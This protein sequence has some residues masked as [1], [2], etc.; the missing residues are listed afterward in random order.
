MLLSHLRRAVEHGVR[1]DILELLS[2]SNLARTNTL[3]LP[4]E[5]Y[6]RISPSPHLPYAVEMSSMHTT[7]DPSTSLGYYIH[8]MDHNRSL[9][10]PRY[11]SGVTTPPKL[12]TILSG[13]L[14]VS[15]TEIQGL[16]RH[17]ETI[18]PPQRE[19]KSSG[20]GLTFSSLW[21]HR[22]KRG[23]GGRSSN[24][25]M[26]TLTEDTEENPRT[27]KPSTNSEG[28]AGMVFS[29]DPEPVSDTE[30]KVD[31][32]PKR[33]HRRRSSTKDDPSHTERE[34][35]GREMKR[36]L[37][38]NPW[39]E[40]SEYGSDSESDGS[41]SP[42]TAQP[43]KPKQTEPSFT[44][45]TP[46]RRS[47]HPNPPPS[48]SSL[49]NHSTHSS[50]LTVV[51]PTMPLVPGH[52]WPPCKANN[53]SGFCKGA[54]KLSSGLGGFKTYTEPIGYYLLISKWRCYRC[55]F[56]MPLAPGS[57]RHDI[58]FDQKIYRHPGTGI[59]YRWSFLAKSHLAYTKPGV[60]AP[61]HVSGS[62]GC[63]FCCAEMNAPAPR[64]ESLEVFMGHLGAQHRA[65]DVALLE[66]TR[67]VVGRVAG[68]EEGFDINIPP[69]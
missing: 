6:Q 27:R 2:T 37:T 52:F 33:K 40:R 28:Y 69:V 19:R 21:S 67:C 44:Q 10:E 32:A 9:S 25:S 1:L 55:Y 11:R 56:G 59:R 24:G 50:S 22:S 30:T 15:P 29:P 26:M 16:S 13:Q 18:F 45:P 7:V 12:S 36:Q 31:K 58:R 14:S 17:G 64:M 8:L 61:T 3:S 20:L 68:D 53:Y 23:S 35:I 48:S 41:I 49:S 57:N 47:S 38:R 63:V 42:T 4:Q 65:M 54:W 46:S 60:S 5:M 66:R 62:F 43:P 34:E 51:P 39:V